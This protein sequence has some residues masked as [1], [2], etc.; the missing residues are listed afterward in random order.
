MIMAQWHADI[1][2]ST[3]TTG[4]KVR[5]LSDHQVVRVVTADTL[6]I[7]TSSGPRISA[8]VLDRTEGKIRLALSDGR[9]ATLDMLLD[10]SLHPPHELPEIYSSQ[11]W[12]VNC[13]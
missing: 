12:L 7:E 13:V 2:G 11:V 5:V 4:T 8:M 6:S 1:D 9:L 10:V 3:L